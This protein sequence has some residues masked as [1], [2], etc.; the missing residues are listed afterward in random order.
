MANPIDLTSYVAGAKN[1]LNYR[2]FDDYM[3]YYTLLSMG[4]SKTY[5]EHIGS[6]ERE[7]I[8][9]KAQIKSNSE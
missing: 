2:G 6:E 3:V 9:N 1:A 5:I 7:I 8:L 4:I